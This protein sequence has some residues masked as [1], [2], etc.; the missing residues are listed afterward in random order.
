MK[1]ENINNT[2][3]I[4]DVH[5]AY[6]SLLKL[7][8]QLPQDAK[9]IFVGDLCDKGKYSKDVIEYVI[10]NN[11]PCV[12]GNHEHLFEKYILDAVERD[13]HSPWSSDKRYGGLACIESYNKDIPLIK[14]HLEWIKKLPVYIEIERYFITHGFALEYYEHRD[15]EEYYNE[16]LLNRYY[17]GDEVP[18]SEVINVF[19]HCTFDEVVSGENFFCIDTSCAYGKKLTAFELGTHKLYEVPMDPRDSDFKADA[20]TMNEY[21]VYEENF[22]SIASLVIDGDSKYG[23]YDIVAN[24]VLIAIVDK[25]GELG[26]KELLRMHERAQIFPKQIKKVLGDEYVKHIKF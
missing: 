7:I 19:G 26:K 12:K 4:G 2:F 14:K 24:E 21:N 11:Y 8:K 13:V 5:G 9:I 20:I 22:E 10:N 6:H 18:E 1:L 25:Y 15:N 17:H 23:E 16:F 3:V